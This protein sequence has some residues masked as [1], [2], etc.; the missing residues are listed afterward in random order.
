MKP[1]DLS[2]PHSEFKTH[3]TKRPSARC[4]RF[5]FTH[6]TVFVPSVGLSVD[7]RH[8]RTIRRDRGAADSYTIVIRPAWPTTV[9]ES[10]YIVTTRPPDVVVT[11][12]LLRRKPPHV[13]TI[14]FDDPKTSSD[15]SS[16]AVTSYACNNNVTCVYGVMFSTSSDCAPPL[17]H[18]NTGSSRLIEANYKSIDG[19]GGGGGFN[20]PNG[21]RPSPDA[22]FS[23]PRVPVR[24]TTT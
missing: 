22:V 7:T 1:T 6:Q 2:L 13:A 8:R 18:K 12:D 4:T 5:T 17:P 23:R 14:G 15:L 3:W 21:R 19:G 20:E 16:P 10:H 9:V 11:R 24:A